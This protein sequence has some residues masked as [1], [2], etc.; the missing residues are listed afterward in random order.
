MDRYRRDRVGWRVA[1][2]MAEPLVRAALR[3]A[4][5]ARQPKPGL[6]HPTDRGGQYAGTRCRAVRG[7]AGMRQSR[8]RADNGYD[9]AFLESC[10]G[11]FQTEMEIAEEES[12][13]AARSAVAEYIDYYR[14]DRKHSSL[15]Y[16]TPVPFTNRVIDPQ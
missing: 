15:G 4:I 1:A 12:A 16:L 3:Q 11:T 14:F 6:I 13:G 7:R 2:S 10:F 5:R 9:N 8:S